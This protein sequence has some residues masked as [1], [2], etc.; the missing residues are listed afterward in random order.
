MINHL[1]EHKK[2]IILVI[3]IVILILVVALSYAWLRTAFNGKKDVKL[4]VGDISIIL[5][6]SSTNGINLVNA[7]PSYDEEGKATEAY[8]FKLKNE[9]NIPLYYTLSLVD[10]NEALE[11]CTTT[12]G[13]DCS[14][15]DPRD[16]RYEIKMDDRTITG[17]LSDSSIINYG[18][19]DSNETKD[20]ELRIWLNLNANNEAMG[21]V[22]L[23]KLRVFA[24]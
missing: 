24:T 8:T 3:A 18:T 6:E 19:I 1:K 14:L 7:I 5:D 12:S 21:K 16:V 15:L 4:V 10:D 9:S 23:G 11:N 20:G 17:T 13:G 22:F 2:I